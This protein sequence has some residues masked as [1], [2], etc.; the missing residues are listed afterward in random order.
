[1]ALTHEKSSN[2]IRRKPSGNQKDLLATHAKQVSLRFID[3]S[4]KN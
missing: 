3:Y 4:C 1:M 2:S